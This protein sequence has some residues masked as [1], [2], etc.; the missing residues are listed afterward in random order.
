VGG[1]IFEEPHCLEALAAGDLEGLPALFIEAAKATGADE[2]GKTFEKA[3]LLAKSA[4][5]KQYSG[6]AR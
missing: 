1:F 4:R 5:L 6:R 2:T 3:Q